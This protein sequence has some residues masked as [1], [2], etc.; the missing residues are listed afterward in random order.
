[1]A[2]SA[3]SATAYLTGVKANYGTIGVTAAVDY[4]D[5]SA[6]NERKNHVSSIASWAQQRGKG[7]GIVTT[8]RV[9]HASPAGLY[10]H[11]G[12]REWECDADVVEYNQTASECLDI[13]SQLIYNQPGSEF[14][15]IFGGGRSKFLPTDVKDDEGSYGERL[16]GSNLINSW[17]KSKREKGKYIYDK[18]GLLNLD[19]NATEYVLG[20]FEPSHLQYNLDTN[21]DTDPTLSELT[22]TAIN[23]LKKEKRG[24]F[25]FVEGGRIDHGH[26]ETRA[27]IALDETIEFAES[28]RLAK[29]ITSREDTLIIV[30]SDHAHTMSIS[31]YSDRGADILG[32]NSKKSDIG[33]LEFCVSDCNFYLLFP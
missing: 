2:D 31:G 19:I 15:V 7:T 11:V 25:L 21:H 5:C 14:K 3:C 8:T 32:L 10:A 9:T 1:M 20:L 22:V 4:N 6:S 17:K 28:V 24:Y 23:L 26:H 18:K 33:E 27:R 30:T 16:D 29:E 12:N 13:A